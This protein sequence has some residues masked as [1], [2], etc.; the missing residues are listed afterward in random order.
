MPVGPLPGSPSTLL[1]PVPD[2]LVT[3]RD[4]DAFKRWINAQPIPRRFRAAWLERWSAASGVPVTADDYRQV[5]G[6]LAP[7]PERL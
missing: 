7:G 2:V 3:G 6:E 1:P 4:L 5:R